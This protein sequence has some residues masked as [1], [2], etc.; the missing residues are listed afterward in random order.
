MIKSIADYYV[1]IVL[2]WGIVNVKKKTQLA[3]L[4]STAKRTF[5][6]C[7]LRA[8]GSHLHLGEQTRFPSGNVLM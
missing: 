4:M 5:L 1:K 6:I 2:K 7:Q 8:A 3:W